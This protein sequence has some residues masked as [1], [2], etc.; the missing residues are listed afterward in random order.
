MAITGQF[1]RA[2]TGGS[3]MASSI[4]NIASDFAALRISRI[5]EAFLNGGNFE[6]EPMDAQ[7]A[8]SLLGGMLD[9]YGDNSKIA[10]DIQQ[11][12]TA[13]RK[14]NRVRILNALDAT[15][16]EEGSLGDWSNKVGVIEDM[17]LDPTLTPDEA[18]ELQ[19]ELS[20]AIDDV[21]QNAQ[22]EFAAGGKITVNGSIIDFAKGANQEQ[23][24]GL[25]DGFIEKYPAMEQRIG[26]ERDLAVS[27]IAVAKA[28]SFWL[29]QKRT[30]DQSK[31]EG[32]NGQLEILKAAYQALQ[33]STYGLGTSPQ[34]I[35]MLEDIRAIQGYKTTV[36][37][38]INTEAA[39]ARLE[40]AS[41]EVF[42]DF[43]LLDKA[44]KRNPVIA[45]MLGDATIGG[46]LQGDQRQI[47]AAMDILDQYKFLNG[48]SKV[49]IGGKTIDFS[50]AGIY[51][52]SSDAQA[53]AR[54]LNDWASGNKY[55]PAN[56]ETAIKS[57]LTGTNAMVK[58][59]PEVRLEDAY[60]T[61]M[62]DFKSAIDGASLSASDR[63]S[64]AKKLGET[65]IGLMTKF[66]GRVDQSVL[67]SLSVEADLYRFGKEPA[68]GER[69]FG[70]QS[71]NYPEY[72]SQG[73]RVLTSG[74]DIYAAGMNPS[75]NGGS[76]SLVRAIQLNNVEVELWNKGQG[77]Y[78]TDGWSQTRTQVVLGEDTSAWQN[79]AGITLRSNTDISVNG[80]SIPSSRNDTYARVRL[81]LPGWENDTSAKGIEIKTAGWITPVMGMDTRDKDGKIIPGE[82]EWVM[83][84]KVGNNEQFISA[85]SVQGIIDLM[86]GN[87]NSLL[88]PVGDKGNL[89][90]PISG[91]AL[92]AFNAS[93]VGGPIS[94][95]LVTAGGADLDKVMYEA[96]YTIVT[97]VDAKQVADIKAA[98]TAGTIDVD[99]NGR[100]VAVDLS[101]KNDPTMGYGDKNTTDITNL[102]P[103]SVGS[104]IIITARDA[105]LDRSGGGKPDYYGEGGT[106]NTPPPYAARNYGTNYT[107]GYGGAQYAQKPVA[108]KPETFTPSQVSQSIVDFRA[109]E[110][111]AAA[112]SAP[113]ATPG[114][115]NGQALLDTFMR[116]VPV[117]GVAPTPPTPGVRPPVPTPP[118]TTPKVPPRPG[119]P[120]LG[121]PPPA[122]PPRQPLPPP[123]MGGR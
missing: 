106:S 103:K 97:S 60:D 55:V 15:L 92:D 116:N 22:N 43:N 68:E 33:D 70:E 110:R 6:G 47:N 66:E 80:T 58:N 96:G 99:V 57:Y 24:L 82:I 10:L 2:V 32:Y 102:I 50:R 23:F 123:V 4:A 109:G 30:T 39:Y 62:R 76:T 31:L 115:S 108:P 3:S 118:P 64:I 119:P 89:V 94:R 59:N 11:T 107:A 78:F 34:A 26:R 35:Q 69:T 38:N 98:I 13:V 8:I 53:A 83:T 120:G 72:D 63:Q 65:L 75:A 100:I 29:D 14:S 122:V 9:E 85:F 51:D 81:M 21:L 95:A 87:P 41:K 12:L 46:M 105:S 37:D 104:Q 61:A 111:A 7:R 19:G 90:I 17:L 117:T 52:M 77:Q 121:T 20:D 27:S 101:T 113:A 25:F 91:G 1:G 45:S 74:T 93:G 49:E 18:I 36:K 67:R 44:M 88:T 28:S 40:T 54:A 48:S 84:K 42:Q 112:R 16:K 5:Y 71:G 73:N 86:G 56:W 79:G 114:Y